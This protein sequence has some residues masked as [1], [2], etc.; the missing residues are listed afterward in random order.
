MFFSSLFIFVYRPISEVFFFVVTLYF[1][2][3]GLKGKI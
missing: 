2:K 3:E 1:L